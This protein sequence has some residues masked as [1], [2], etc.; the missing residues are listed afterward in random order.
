[1]CIDLWDG[2]RREHV[3]LRAFVRVEFRG[4]PVNRKVASLTGQLSLPILC[5]AL[6][7]YFERRRK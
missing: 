4:E 6:V 3:T 5:A 7:L 1:M 2:A